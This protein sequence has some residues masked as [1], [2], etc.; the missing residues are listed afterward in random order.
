V[1]ITDVFFRRYRGVELAECVTADERRFFHQANKLMGDRLWLG[2]PEIEKEASES[3]Q[4]GLTIVH[5]RIALELGVDYLSDLW[6][7]YNKNPQKNSITQIVRNFMTMDMKPPV[8]ADQYIKERLSV[9]ELALR[10]RGE[11]VQQ[12][13]LDHPRKLAEAQLRDKQLETRPGM[14]VPGFAVVGCKAAHDK[15]VNGYSAL[16]E[17]INERLRIEGFDLVYSNGL[18]HMAN[19]ELSQDVVAKPFWN[20]VA[21]PMW[22]NV[23]EQMKEA[24]DRRDKRDRTSAFHAVCALESCMKIVFNRIVP[25]APKTPYGHGLVDQLAKDERFLAKW[26]A[27]MLKSMFSDVRNPFAHGPGKGDMPEFSPEQ[28]QWAIDT[29]MSWIKSLVRRL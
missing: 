13:Q 8:T 25:D 12:I 22:A 10:I 18:L 21:Q 5:D 7:Y 29:S 23:E 9:V 16:V 4:K 26:E 24:L 19:D 2:A 3:T 1:A 11:Q 15:A 20:V 14:R 6:W 27:D 17:E 28:T